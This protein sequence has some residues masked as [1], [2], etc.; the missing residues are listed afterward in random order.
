MRRRWE[1]NVAG[2][3]QS[4][5]ADAAGFQMWTIG[6]DMHSKWRKQPDI[7][8]IAFFD[9]YCV[10]S[11]MPGCCLRNKRNTRQPLSSSSE[12]C[13]SQYIKTLW[14]VWAMR[15]GKGHL[16]ASVTTV[17][18][19]NC[20]CYKQML[21]YAALNFKRTI[22]LRK[23]KLPFFLGKSQFCPFTAIAL[24]RKNIVH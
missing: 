15:T 8:S 23:A 10:R 7:Q 12:G 16:P 9:T 13:R 6:N 4:L 20:I 21:Y 11:A 24:S 22:N 3:P 2:K 14:K 17:Q 5:G 1:R 19:W 18:D